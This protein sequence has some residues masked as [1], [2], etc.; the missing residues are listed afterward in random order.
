MKKISQNYRPR[1]EWPFYYELYEGPLDHPKNKRSFRYLLL[2]KMGVYIN[3]YDYFNY[4]K[5]IDHMISSFRK[6]LENRE[7]TP[8][9]I[10]KLHKV[11]E[12]CEKMK[13][14]T[15]ESKKYTITHITDGFVE[16]YKLKSLKLNK[17]YKLSRYTLKGQ[18]RS[19]TFYIRKVHCKNHPNTPLFN[20]NGIDVSD[21]YKQ[22]LF[23]WL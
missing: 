5:V 1:F 21:Q 2:T 15:S 22:W 4:F 16:I 9:Q 11:I 13:T 20:Y 23:E 14:E 3:V 12:S 8:E 7:L 10:G 19:A 17:L 18:E 6:S